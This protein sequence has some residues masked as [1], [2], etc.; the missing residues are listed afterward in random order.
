[1][2]QAYGGPQVNCPTVL[3]SRCSTLD[4]ANNL[5]EADTEHSL[6]DAVACQKPAIDI[7]WSVLSYLINMEL[8]EIQ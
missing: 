3:N 5:G 6:L 8:D 7:F 1:M 2:M 4:V